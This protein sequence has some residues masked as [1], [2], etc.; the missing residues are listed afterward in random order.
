[1]IPRIISFHAVVI[2][3]LIFQ[4]YSD[5]PWPCFFR[6][7]FK[8]LYTAAY[9]PWSEI[10]QLPVPHLSRVNEKWQILS[11]FSSI[12]ALKKVD[13]QEKKVFNGDER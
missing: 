7:D 4:F 11:F 3:V 8:P 9:R 2:L 10:S 12:L 13:Q 6:K 1:M 5:L